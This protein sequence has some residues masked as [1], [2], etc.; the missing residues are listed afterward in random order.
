MRK[1]QN[2]NHI[3]RNNFLFKEQIIRTIREYFY[4]RDFQEMITPVFNETIPLEPNIYPFSTTWITIKGEKKFYLS[5]SPEKYLK[6][7]LAEGI[8][9]CF[10]ISHTFRNLEDES[11]IHKP[12]FLM[13]EW[14]R[15]GADYREIM[16]ETRELISYISNEIV[17]LWGS[18]GQ[19]RE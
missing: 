9:N 3:H 13:L 6:K 17:L 10:S 12:E 11:P 4:A 18:P 19:A 2:I 5:T 8:G 16:E 15:M 14:Y 1:Q 7:M